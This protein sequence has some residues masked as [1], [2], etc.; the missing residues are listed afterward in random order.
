MNTVL[1]TIIFERFSFGNSRLHSS[2][3][4]GILWQPHCA[5]MFQ[6]DHTR[7]AVRTSF[8]IKSVT[9]EVK[10]SGIVRITYHKVFTNMQSRIAKGILV[11]ERTAATALESLNPAGV[12]PLSP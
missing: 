3:V 9:N 5:V 11:G 7:R 12:S 1:H 10:I 2:F 6:L 8:N 4:S